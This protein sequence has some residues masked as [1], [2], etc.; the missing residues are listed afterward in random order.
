MD[1]VFLSISWLAGLYLGLSSAG[2]VQRA[3]SATAPSPA[4][5]VQPWLAILI[6]LASLAVLL[7]GG[8]R[9]LRIIAASLAFGLLAV[10]RAFSLVPAADTLPSGPGPLTVSGTVASRP[11]PRDAAQTLVLEVDRLR[12]GGGWEDARARV[13]VRVDRYQDWAYGDRVV[14]RGD[15]RPVDPSSGYWA[16]Y[17][18]RQGI[19][20]TLEY[21]GMQLVERPGQPDLRRLI[22]DLR[23]RLDSVCASLMPEPQASLLAGILVGS[24][25]TMPPEFRDALNV[26]STSHIVAV[27]GFNVTLLA[28][29][30]QLVALRF[31]SRRK[32]TLLSILV[33]WSYAL[34][35][36]L[37]PSAT[38]AALMATMALAAVLAG[39][40]GDALSFLCF[41]GALMTALDPLVLYDLG[42]QLSFLATAGLVMLEPVLRRLM[43]RLPAWLSGSLSVT[44]AAQLATLPVLISNFQLVSLVSPLSNLLIAPVLPSLMGLGGATVILG[45]VF[46][47]VGDLLAPVTWLHLTYLVEVIRWT[48]RLPGASV[49]TGSL[50]FAPVLLYY[51]LLLSIAVWPMAEIR[52]ARDAVMAF[53]GATPRWLLPGGM[54]A[55]IAISGIAFSARPDGRTHIYFL[56]V[57]QGD[58]ALIRGPDGHQVL[59][60]GGPSP[61]SILGALGERLGFADR[62][63]DAVILTGYEESRL[64]GLLEVIKRHPVGVVVQPASPPEN[65]AGR[66]W[67]AVLAERGIPVVRAVPGLKIALGAGSQLEV[68]WAPVQGW[69][70]SEQEA[71][72]VARLVSHGVNVVLPGDLALAT[73][74]RIVRAMAGPAEVLRV[75]RNGAAGSLDERFVQALS[76][77]LAVVSLQA[78]NRQ[79]NPSDSTVELLRSSTL[80]RTD[81]QGTV[82]ISIDRDGYRVFTER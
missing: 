16:E 10:C 8:D 47:P 43:G 55:L 15:L 59:V 12:H 6:A 48:A 45:A 70:G 5:L 78:G 17:L 37:P 41:S 4:D 38:R 62:R 35:T 14:A 29:A 3:Q 27:S 67:S 32:A 54:A 76:P 64:N 22:D 56:D 21:P 2:A 26:T 66:A 19:Y 46:P 9:R 77:R 75:P 69:E 20:H 1:L 24:R 52:I 73:Q 7:A 60:D 25:A 34:L 40:G 50:G 23:N 28:A 80:L 63:L 44:M 49:A 36:G 18:G 39:R 58:A 57:G 42:F 33:V 74:A 30:A 53:L 68:V 65:G 81:L 31:L 72:L 82:E 11:E 51:L 79:Q 13:L 71:T 61:T